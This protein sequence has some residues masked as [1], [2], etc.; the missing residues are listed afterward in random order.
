MLGGKA[1]GS[2]RGSHPWPKF[3]VSFQGSD[4]LQFS[5][6]VPL[7]NHS[8]DWEK[9]TEG[10][11]EDDRPVLYLI[12]TDWMPKSMCFAVGTVYFSFCNVLLY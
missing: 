8:S 9:E 1:P 3:F 11:V 7:K 12:V 5:N 6:I 4:P 10:T 2:Q